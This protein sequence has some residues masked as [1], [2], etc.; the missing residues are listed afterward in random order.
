MERLIEIEDPGAA[1]QSTSTLP[2]AAAAAGPARERGRRVVDAPTRMFHWL[3]AL[4]FLG[5]FVTAD[6][7]RARELHIALGYLFAGLLVFRALYGLL[8]PRPARLAPMLRRLAG[9]PAWLRS[10]L[11][12][13]SITGVDWRQGENLFIVSAVAAM[14]AG[15]VP[16][17][18]SGYGVYEDWAG[19]W[20]EDAHEFL[21]NAFLAVAMAHVVAIVGFGRMRGRN[22]VAPMITGRVAGP[23]P[24]VVRRNGAWLAVLMLVA[25]LAFVG[26]RLA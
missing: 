9:A 26:W 3:F 6:S 5:A 4:S 7:E 18:L 11:R 22:R 8:G 17:V 12:A 14:L 1:M 13:R 21:G 19:D 10:T 25:S 2:R 16:L 24:D 20:L 15:V 23:G